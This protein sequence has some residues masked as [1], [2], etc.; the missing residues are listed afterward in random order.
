MT[1]CANCA[2]APGAQPRTDESIR[3][4]REFTMKEKEAQ[5]SKAASKKKKKG[6]KPEGQLPGGWHRGPADP[7]YQGEERLVLPPADA[8]N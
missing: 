3:E 7:E 2:N 1:M 5:A 8:F 4:A 6:K